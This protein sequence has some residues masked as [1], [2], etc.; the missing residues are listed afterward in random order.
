MLRILHLEQFLS[1]IEKTERKMES[2]PEYVQNSDVE[3]QSEAKDAEKQNAMLV[4]KET[5]S[6]AK[7]FGLSFTRTT[8]ETISKA[9]DDQ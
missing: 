4:S 3:K 7:G 1:K 2:L 8:K 9:C 6:I 5:K